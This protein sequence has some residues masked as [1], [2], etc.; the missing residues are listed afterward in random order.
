METS[1]P[2]EPK[3]TPSNQPCFSATAPIGTTGVDLVVLDNA[4]VTAID[5]DNQNGDGFDDIVIGTANSHVYKYVGSSGGLQTPAGAF[6]TTASAVV[7]VKFGNVSG[8]QS[9][10]EVV[11]AFG[12]TVRVLTGFGATG[13]FITPALPAFL[14]GNAITAFAV[15]DINGD[16]PDDVAIGTTTDV[17]LWINQNN[18]I[19]W[20]PAIL[21]NSYAVRVYSIDLGDAGKSQ[22]LGR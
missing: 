21:V 4:A 13:N 1:A 18:G 2:G 10:L 11:V 14:P 17:F 5:A 20:T 22:Y 6:Y 3:R 12:T 15:G 16:G 7:G 9:G 19:T 8:T